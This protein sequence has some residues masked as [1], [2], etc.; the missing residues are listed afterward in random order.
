M[1]N[2]LTKIFKESGDLFPDF[3]HPTFDECIEKEKCPSCLKQAGITPVFKKG[4]FQIITDQSA[5][6]QMS[7]EYLKNLCSNKCQI[8]FIKLLL[9]INAI[10]GKLLVFSTKFSCNA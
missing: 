2:I 5:F 9:Y 4:I 7:Q 8:F 6:Y 10:L 1:H 3:L